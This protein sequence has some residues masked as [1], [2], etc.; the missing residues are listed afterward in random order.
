MHC[1]NST[2]ATVR[3]KTKGEDGDKW[4]RC[5]WQSMKSCQE[6][7]RKN[8][9]VV[10]RRHSGSFVTVQHHVM[11]PVAV[12][13]PRIR[14]QSC[15][16][17]RISI[18]CVARWHLVAMGEKRLVL[19]LNH[20]LWSFWMFSCWFISPASPI[21]NQFPLHSVSWQLPKCMILEIT[22]VKFKLLWKFTAESLSCGCFV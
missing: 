17:F 19:L 20:Q 21:K 18:I 4:C 11:V 5:H 8:N 9:L 3:K 16:F 6:G 10:E 1:D 7:K 14:N 2:T 15:F 12:F 13:H 22:P